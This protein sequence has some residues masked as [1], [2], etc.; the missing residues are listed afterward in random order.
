MNDNNKESAILSLEYDGAKL[1]GYKLIPLYDGQV[2]D[3]EQGDNIL[4]KLSE[5]SNRLH[6]DKEAYNEKRTYFFNAYL[7]SRKSK[8]N[9]NWYLKRLNFNSIKMIVNSKLNQKRYKESITKYL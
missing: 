8:R 3:K 6:E 2:C 9:V 4:L 7:K 1:I 5:Y